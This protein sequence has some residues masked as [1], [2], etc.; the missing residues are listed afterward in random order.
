M[1]CAAGTHTLHILRVQAP[2]PCPPGQAGL[3]PMQHVLHICVVFLTPHPLEHAPALRPTQLAHI[4][5][6]RCK[7][8]GSL[9]PGPR[10]LLALHRK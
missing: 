8:G 3:Y 9:L 5:H 2:L 7:P 10:C 1:R 4:E 6:L